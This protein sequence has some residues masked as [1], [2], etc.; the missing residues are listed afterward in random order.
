[1]RKFGG[2]FVAASCGISLMGFTCGGDDSSNPLDAGDGIDASGLDSG[3]KSETSTSSDGGSEASTGPGTVTGIV[4][5]DVPIPGAKILIGT[6]T[7]T[8][9][10]DGTFTI[11]N[12]ADTYTMT[13]V[14]PQFG[15]I[16]PGNVVSYVGL[17]TRSP[18]VI[19]GFAPAT[20]QLHSD[21]AVISVNVSGTSLSTVPPNQLNGIL[22]SPGRPDNV[23][24]TAGSLTP[25]SFHWSTTNDMQSADLYAYIQDPSNAIVSM[26]VDPGVVLPSD[27]GT[28]YPPNLGLVTPGFTTI[29]GTYS[30]PAGYTVDDADSACIISPSANEGYILIGTTSSA[31]SSYT[32]GVPAGLGFAYAAAQITAE[33][34]DGSQTLRTVAAP[35][36]TGTINITLDPA[37][38]LTAPTDG[39]SGVDLTQP[40]TWTTPTTSSPVGHVLSV[41]FEFNQY[42]VLALSTA[43]ATLPDLSALGIAR[44]SW[45]STQASVGDYEGLV[46][47]D[48]VDGKTAVQNA[49]TGSSP[50]ITFATQ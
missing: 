28:V 43:S 24:I 49:A 30:V 11:P 48:F 35:G 29:G 16:H 32:C 25:W 39:A 36:G 20:S 19:N 17:T 42:I 7:A 23:A 1:M 9:G 5:E 13:V 14:I 22:L 38:L 21:Q 10:A 4:K 2:F 27:G 45:D 34:D 31:T 47:D 46:M 8:T 33:G 50:I 44:P 26:A 18:I 37:A 41:Q 15:G 12:V 3:N 40:F 6:A